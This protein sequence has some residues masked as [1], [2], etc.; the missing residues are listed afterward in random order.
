MRILKFL[1]VVQMLALV[2][3]VG[4]AI[5][6]LLAWAIGRGQ[7]EEAMRATL[8]I[9]SET[10]FLLER[11]YKILEQLVESDTTQPRQE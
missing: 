11:F 2:F 8:A 7:V 6:F 10:V 5:G 1:S 3:V 4:F 9:A